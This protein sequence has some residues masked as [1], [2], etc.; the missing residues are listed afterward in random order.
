MWWTTGVAAFL[1]VCALQ[2][3]G[4]SFVH[5]RGPLNR[6]VS[7]QVAV[8]QPK[9]V[10]IELLLYNTGAAHGGPEAFWIHLH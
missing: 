9:F 2:S 6:L 1:L 5:S 3:E 10:L 8:N 4:F 7:E